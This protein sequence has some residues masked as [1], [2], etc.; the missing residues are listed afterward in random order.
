MDESPYTAELTRAVEAAYD[1]FGRGHLSGQLEVC[2]C[3]V[4]MTEDARA[5]I[6][7][8]RNDRLSVAQICDYSNSAHGVPRDLDDL[9][10]LL[11]RYLDLMAGDE[12]VDDMGVGTELL[13]FGDAVR[14]HP[15]LFSPA[16]RRVLDDWSRAMMW[17]FAW[18]DTTEDGAVYAPPALLETLL[19]GGWPLAVLTGALEDIF[20]DPKLGPNSLSVL[21]GAVMGRARRKHGRLAPDWFALRYCG[22]AERAGLIAWLN[23]VAGSDRALD[24]A[25]G[26]AETALW[27]QSFAAAAGQFDA[28]LLPGRD[29]PA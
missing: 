6:V 14:T 24:L 12:L 4:C 9:K 28:A 5:G 10:L 29:R 11:P 20:A 7:A 15:E 19:C 23:A 17:H 3:P 1:A 25:T 2:L 26:Q 27:V 18:A 8:T 21:A 13:R 22:E 16:E